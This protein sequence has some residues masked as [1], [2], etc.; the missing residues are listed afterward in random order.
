ML[1]VVVV[2]LFRPDAATPAAPVKKK[3]T[4]AVAVNAPAPAVEPKASASEPVV[5]VVVEKPALRVPAVE[6]QT[7]PPPEKPRYL[8]GDEKY[9]VDI[10]KWEA[11]GSLR[12]F[13][14]TGW[15][16]DFEERDDFQEQI[17]LLKSEWKDGRWSVMVSRPLKADY[18]EDTYFEVGKYSPTVFFV[19]DGHNGDIGRKMSVSAFYYTIL[20][21]PIPKETYIYPTLIAVGIVILEGWVLTRRANKRKGKL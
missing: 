10:I 20:E 17:K 21:P 18:E 15:D 19:W 3:P 12:A 13:T 7:P 8:W 2:T 16:Q 5:S 9:P 4:V 14:G 1:A 6:E 11:D